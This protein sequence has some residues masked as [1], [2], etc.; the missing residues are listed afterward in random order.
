MRIVIL[1]GGFG[2]LT[3]ATELRKRLGAEHEIV[4]VDR[5]DS[6]VMGLRKLWVLVGAGTLDEGRRPLQSLAHQGIRVLRTEIRAIDPAVRV[7]RTEAGELSADFLVVSLGAEPAPERVPGMG[8]HAFNLYDGASVE[9]AAVRVAELAAGRIVMAI[10]GVPYKCPPAPYE[11]IMLLDDFYRRSGRREGIE[12]SLTTM[13]PMLLPNAGPE[14]ARWMGQELDRRG[15]QHQVGRKVVR[16]EAGRI[17]YADGELSCDVAL[18]APP[19]TSPAVVRQSGLT[20]DGGWI[21]VDPGTLETPF[22]RVYAIGDVTHI[23][24]ANQM[25]LPKAG[26]MAEAHGLRVAQAIVAELQGGSPP[27]PFDGHGFCFVET[28]GGQAAAIEGDFYATP[29]P[30]VRVADPTEAGMLGKQR[31]ESER[32]GRWFGH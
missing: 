10:A 8:E 17:V 11:A 23:P 6:F 19:H 25:P 26:V 29:A 30:A 18:I 32:L 16:V 13:Q 15:I 9:A 22:P 1:G 12:L 7:V 4:L 20:N 21:V 2:G 14:G 24:L 28:G 5:R 3:V 27:P 31:F